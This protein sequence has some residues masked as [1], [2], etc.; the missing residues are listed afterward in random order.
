MGKAPLTPDQISFLNEVIEYLVKNGLMDPKEMYESPF[1][2][3]HNMGLTGV[4]GED[5]AK[6]VVSLVR[7]VAENADV[8]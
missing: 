1:T 4:M 3:Y 8:A 7:H 5:L 6:Q 2:H